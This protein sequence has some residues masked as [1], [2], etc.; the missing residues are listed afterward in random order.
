MEAQ[1]SES[2][3]AL[4][5]RLGQII[6]GNV[7]AIASAV[8]ETHDVEY[9]D[10]KLRSIPPEERQRWVESSVV[11]M[12]RSIEEDAPVIWSYSYCP[13]VKGGFDPQTPPFVEISN[14]YAAILAMEDCMLP[15][16]WEAYAPD[17]NELLRAVRRFRV[18]ILRFIDANVEALTGQIEQQTH[19][20]LETAALRERDRVVQELGDY[21]SSAVYGLKEKMGL[22]YASVLAGEN[23]EAL[24]LITATK[25]LVSDVAERALSLKRESARDLRSAQVSALEA[26][27]ATAEFAPTASGSVASQLPVTPEASR[28]LEPS[29]TDTLAGWGVTRREIEV[30]KGVALGKTNIEIAGDLNLSLGTVRNYTSSLLEKLQAENRTQLA[31]QAVKAGLV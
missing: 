23:D 10:S 21:L 29:E 14:Q 20:T 19:E 31:V 17:T 7:T 6:Q 5:A 18:H 9:P 22:V 13:N 27:I 11:Y 4:D 28:S 2:V 15:F 24:S 26:A 30:L 16:I 3:R 12:V 25:L 1:E 8:I